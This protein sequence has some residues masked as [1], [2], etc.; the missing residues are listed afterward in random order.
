MALCSSLSGFVAENVILFSVYD[1]LWLWSDSGTGPNND[2]CVNESC[3]TSEC[4][5]NL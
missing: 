5:V 3:V 2:S 1:I 4:F